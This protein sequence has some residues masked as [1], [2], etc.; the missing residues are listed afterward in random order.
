MALKRVCFNKGKVE[1][2][3]QLMLHSCGSSADANSISCGKAKCEAFLT[4]WS[5][6]EFMILRAVIHH[7]CNVAFV[8]YEMLFK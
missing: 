1:D 5:E 8:D 3:P 4:F 2:S 6:P 7:C